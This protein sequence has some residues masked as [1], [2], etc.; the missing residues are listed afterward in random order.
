MARVYLDFQKLGEGDKLINQ[1]KTRKDTI[2]KYQT[3]LVEAKYLLVR[4]DTAKAMTLLG[5]L[6][7]QNVLNQEVI[8]TLAEVYKRKKENEKGYRLMYD[9]IHANTENAEIWYYLAYFTR[10]YGVLEDAKFD[11]ERA[12]L[13]SPNPK[14]KEEIAREFDDLFNPKETQEVQ[15]IE[16]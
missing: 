2:H 12:I 1:L 13:L 3:E 9:A 5:K 8:T 7:K 14:R 4:K 15:K 10:A 6:F 16:L 11:A